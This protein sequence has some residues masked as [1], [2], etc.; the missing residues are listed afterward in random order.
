MNL[1]TIFNTIITMGCIFIINNISSHIL[2]H[3]VD[4]PSVIIPFYK[5]YYEGELYDNKYH[6]TGIM[7]FY[8]GSIYYK[9][10]F[11][12]NKFHGIGIMYNFDKTVHYNGIWN[13]GKKLKSSEMLNNIIK[14]NTY[15][16]LML[17][18]YNVDICTFNV[19]FSNRI[20]PYNFSKILSQ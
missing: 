11:L 2:Y 19:L 15:Q 5:V 3:C 7:Y 1:N 4:E 20:E 9:G 18:N 6:G 12:N 17:N 8:D 13:E 16:M 14:Y 10:E